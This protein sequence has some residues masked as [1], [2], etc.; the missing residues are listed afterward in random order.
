MRTVLDTTPRHDSR[1]TLGVARD[2]LGQLRPRLDWRVNLDDRRAL[3]R[4]VVLLSARVSEAGLGTVVTDPS[5]DTL[6]W[7][8]SFEGGRHHMG[9]TRMHSDPKCGVVDADC[10]VHGME[11]LYASGSSVFTTPGYANPTLTIVALALR[12]ADHLRGR[13]AA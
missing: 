1:M 3:D 13:L 4:L 10:R 11:N 5:R 7:P 9:T 12:L 8:V 2:S 6:G